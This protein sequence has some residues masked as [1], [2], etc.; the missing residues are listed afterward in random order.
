[1]CTKKYIILIVILVT[2]SL[3]AGMYLVMVI[4]HLSTT[5]EL[6]ISQTNKN[7]KYLKYN[8]VVF[9]NQT[10][11]EKLFKLVEA[12]TDSIL[13]GST[14]SDPNRWWVGNCA[15]YSFSADDYSGIAWPRIIKDSIQY[16]LDEW[17]QLYPGL[18]IPFISQ[19]EICPFG[20]QE[21]IDST[22][23]IIAFRINIGYEGPYFSEEHYL[24][25]N[26]KLV[27]LSKKN[28][29]REMILMDTLIW[30][31]VHYSIK[32]VPNPND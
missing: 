7:A 31:S 25:V 30:N 16:I 15:Y 5:D 20:T 17:N 21:A 14:T 26:K 18:T 27:I 23:S 24:S 19:M 8:S 22:K 3:W 29:V 12:N 13:A 6:I 11:I 32:L 10:R 1:M 28:S 9:E 2:T 4:N